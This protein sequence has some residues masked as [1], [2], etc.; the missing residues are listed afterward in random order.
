MTRDAGP[1][2]RSGVTLEQLKKALQTERTARGAARHLQVSERTVRRMM[3][4]LRFTRR[5]GRPV[6][7][8]ALRHREWLSR[9]A[10]N[11]LRCDQIAKHLNAELLD[12]GETS[13]ITAEGVRSAYRRLG[14]TPPRL[15]RERLSLRGA[16]A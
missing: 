10:D 3:D 4:D 6:A 5:R 8:P 15:K 2:S 14:L 16:G 11:G 13:S 9:Q 12:S 1:G 7:H